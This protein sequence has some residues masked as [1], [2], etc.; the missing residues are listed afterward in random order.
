MSEIVLHIP[1]MEN[2]IQKDYIKSIFSQLG[3][4]K[5]IKEI[6]YSKYKQIFVHLI[7][8]NPEQL[9]VINTLFTSYQCI[10]IVHSIPWYWT[11]YKYTNPIYIPNPHIMA[12]L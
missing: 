7:M 11:C 5:Q 3:T 8:D 4:I 10:K 6:P 2:N 12:E 9:N 1:K